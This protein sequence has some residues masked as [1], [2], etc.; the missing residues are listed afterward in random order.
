MDEAQFVGH[1]GR[2]DLRDAARAESLPF[3]SPVAASTKR[4]SRA[5]DGGAHE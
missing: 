1:K 4:S 2:N 3:S 5:L